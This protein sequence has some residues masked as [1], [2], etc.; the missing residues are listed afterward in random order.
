[1]PLKFSFV[2]CVPIKTRLRACPI[3]IITHISPSIFIAKAF[4]NAPKQFQ[5]NAQSSTAIMDH[6]AS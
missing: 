5:T 3:N 2:A 4:Q 1:M 6:D